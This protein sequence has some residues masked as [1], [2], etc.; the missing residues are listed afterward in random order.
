MGASFCKHSDQ[1]HEFEDEF[2]RTML[3]KVQTGNEKYSESAAGVIHGL[4]THGNLPF[5][6]REEVIASLQEVTRNV[7]QSQTTEVERGIA[8]QAA[9]GLVYL[10]GKEEKSFLATNPAVVNALIMVTKLARQRQHYAGLGHEWGIFGMLAPI[11]TLVVSDA[12]K[13]ILVQNSY[14]DIVLHILNIV[15]FV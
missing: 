8:C 13:K 12:N 15:H 6:L 7:N 10:I 14:M 4:T 11:E 2:I 3:H 5:H 9:I 1:G